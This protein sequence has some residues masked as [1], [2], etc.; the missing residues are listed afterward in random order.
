MKL[1][2]QLAILANPICTS[3]NELASSFLVKTKTRKIDIHLLFLFR[4]R[5]KVIIIIT[6]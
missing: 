2:V 3:R 1:D 4:R 6:R 5:L